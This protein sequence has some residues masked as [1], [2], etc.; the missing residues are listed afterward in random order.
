MFSGVM[1]VAGEY[2]EPPLSPPTSGQE[3]T[4][5]PVGCCGGTCSRLHEQTQAA[6]QTLLNQEQAEA[7]SWLGFGHRIFRRGDPL[8]V[9]AAGVHNDIAITEEEQRLCVALGRRL[10]RVSAR[11]GENGV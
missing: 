6:A 11:L 4:G 10:A 8:Q 9:F 2:L 3:A 5:P 1:S 7:T